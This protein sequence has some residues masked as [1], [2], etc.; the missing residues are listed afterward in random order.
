MKFL[1]KKFFSEE[2]EL[3]FMQ[4]KWT[5]SR[6]FPDWINWINKLTS[7][8]NTFSHCF[9]LFILGGPC[10]LFWLQTVF[11]RGPY[12]PLK[13]TSL[14]RFGKMNFHYYL[15]HIS[16]IT[17]QSLNFCSKST[18]RPFKQIPIYVNLTVQLLPKH[19]NIY[20]T[21]SDNMNIRWTSCRHVR[22]SSHMHVWIFQWG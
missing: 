5:N 18:Q 15:I 20:S 12:F 13:T 6:C 9:V 16:N 11:L 19:S 3:L 4:T 2:K 17:I 10:H 8:N 21:W 7:K 1:V 22:A 14:Y